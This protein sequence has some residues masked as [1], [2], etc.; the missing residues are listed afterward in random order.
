M[1]PWPDARND[2]SKIVEQFKFLQSHLT[3]KSA[4]EFCAKS[5]DPNFLR[6]LQET[7]HLHYESALQSYLICLRTVV[8][9]VSRSTF[10]KIFRKSCPG[11]ATLHFL[12]ILFL[13]PILENEVN[14]L[15]REL[16][17]DPHGD[18]LHRNDI[19][20]M[21]MM[22]RQAPE[23]RKGCFL[24]NGDCENLA[25]ESQGYK[26]VQMI[27]QLF[28]SAKFLDLMK[29][30]PTL[31]AQIAHEM[32]RSQTD[33][34]KSSDQLEELVSKYQKFTSENKLDA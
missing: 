33:S 13:H 9:L 6:Q 1:M 15:F 21:T 2:E 11:C 22:I 8:S 27:G 17:S 12:S 19:R 7:S 25:K 16:L 30:N 26:I 10:L 4:V 31:G 23:Y 14:H 32:M 18:I 3:A 28:S 5:P 20:Q 34:E 29:S 24:L